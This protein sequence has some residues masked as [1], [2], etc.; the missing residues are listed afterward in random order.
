[1]TIDEFNDRLKSLISEVEMSESNTPTQGVIETLRNEMG[2]LETCA[3]RF[4]HEMQ[5]TY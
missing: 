2:R 3:T 1:M 5:E 4:M